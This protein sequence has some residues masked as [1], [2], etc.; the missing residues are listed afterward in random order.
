MS[1]DVIRKVR[2]ILSQGIQLISEN[3]IPFTG[4]SIDPAPGA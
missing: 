2:F 1:S 4:Q 3:S